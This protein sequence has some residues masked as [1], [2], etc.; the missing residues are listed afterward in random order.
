MTDFKPKNK[1]CLKIVLV[2]VFLTTIFLFYPKAWAGVN[3]LVIDE[4]RI[5]GINAYDEYVV[6]ANY[7]T[8]EINLDKYNLVRKTKTGTSYNYLYHFSS[9]QT[10]K[11]KQRIII[12]HAKFTGQPD[13]R[14]DNSSAYL[15]ADNTIYL[16]GPT[17]E[18]IDKVGYGEVY[19]FEGLPLPNPE[20]NVAYKRIDGQ[21]TS[22]NFNDFEA[23][24]EKI[25]LDPNADKIL[26][27]ELMP[28]PDVGD[29][30]FELYN[31][32]NLIV[33][34]KGLKICDRV[35]RTHCYIFDDQETINP[36]QYKA[37]DEAVTKITLNNDGDWLELQDLDGNILATSGDNYGDAE[38]DASYGLF[39]F[40][41]AWTQTVTKNGANIFTALADEEK[42]AKK[43]KKA[44]SKKA[45]ATKAK[46]TKDSDQELAEKIDS[47][48][49]GIESVNSKGSNQ[50]SRKEVG[51]FLVVL[52]VLIPLG[53]TIWD[54]KEKLSEIFKQ[55]SR[56]NH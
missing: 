44:S 40:G 22:N 29:E 16:L 38:S 26:I 30:W 8:N 25:T 4:F 39:S 43:S 13:L 34:L 51:I 18:I 27:T 5:D 52:A 2:F 53:Y 14:Y 54:R 20:V 28:D 42:K 32:T 48:V 6:I 49:K 31:P 50:F 15:S 7:G 46:T 47:E 41:W 35:G 9:G 45:K 55:L 21:D 1:L 23:I 10:I 36:R 56:K 12:G 37:F 24:L 3:G 19:D 17:K 11:P 33:Q